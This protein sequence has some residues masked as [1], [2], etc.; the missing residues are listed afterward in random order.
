MTKLIYKKLI[1]DFL[2]DKKIL[3]LKYFLCALILY[4]F[5]SVVASRLNAKLFASLDIKKNFKFSLKNE[6]IKYIIYIIILYTLILIFQYI[7]QIIETDFYPSYSSFVRT[8]IFKNTIKK[9]SNEY[10]DIKIGKYIS[11]NVD[12]TKEL[13]TLINKIINNVIISIIVILFIIGY[14]LFLNY[15]IGLIF[16]VSL[17]IITL[18]I[19]FNS[20]I[21]IDKATKK[22]ILNLN[23]SEKLSDSLSN[24]ANI[25]LNNQ[26]KNEVA[27]NKSTNKEIEDFTKEYYRYSN[28]MV[29]GINIILYITLICVSLYTIYMYINKK[30]DKVLVITVFILM[31]LYFKILIKFGFNICDVFGR[32]GYVNAS[33]NF[34]EFIYNNSSNNDADSFMKINSG[35]IVFKNISFGYKKNN[36]IFNNLNLTIAPNKI[37]GI[38]GQ[39]GSGKTTISKLILKLYT[40]SDGDIFIDNNN[41]KK[42]DTE[43]I[44]DN[45][46]YINQRTQLFNTSIIE[47]IKYGNEHI[48]DEY[49]IKYIKENDLDTIFKNV[50]D[51]I[52]SNVGVN[53]NNLSLGMQKIV[54]IL[55]GI[56][57]SNYKIIIFDEP[58][59]GLDKNSRK[60][61]IK[62]IKNISE[63]KTVII[64]THDTEILDITD[65]IIEMN[66]IVSPI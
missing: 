23:M 15:K 39:S 19:Y 21:I 29:N 63:N 8:N 4:F 62:L 57:K 44:R 40:P 30:V 59:A 34:I 54:I 32:I 37:T 33:N 64:I 22:S 41:L 12:I 25:Y 24:L 61:I 18:F 52:Y 31:F 2:Y 42:L 55:R 10:Q 50:K 26:S 49:I 13:N 1:Y 20:F 60:K 7:S 3:V 6:S 38:L 17:I 46:I 48:D 51:G 35:E 9:F 5:E 53:G 28:N 56:M 43:Y 16:L 45:I 11:R 47:N 65:N 36:L 27:T 14:L 58:L 66:K